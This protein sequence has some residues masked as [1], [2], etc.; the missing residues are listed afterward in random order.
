MAHA[1]SRRRGL[2]CDKR[3]HR[4]ANVLLYIFRCGLFSIAADF[5]N[6]DH[7]FRVGIFVEQLESIDKRSADNRI[8]TDADRGGLSDAALRKLIYSFV[9]Q[10]SRSGEDTDIPFFVDTTRHDSD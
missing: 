1:A 3:H 4:L 7:G 8:A 6:H 5:T 9:G 2:S 10:S